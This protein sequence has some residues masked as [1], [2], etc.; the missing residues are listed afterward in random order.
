MSVNGIGAM[1]SP[2]WYGT[3]KADQS[4]LSET[5]S[6]KETVAEKAAEERNNSEEKAFA[7]GSV[8]LIAD[9]TVLPSR[10][11]ESLIPF[12]HLSALCTIIFEICVSIPFPDIPSLGAL[13]Q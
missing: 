2:A 3:K 1:G 5:L 12:I 13:V 10:S 11:F 6:F 4:A 9:C 8:T 7:S